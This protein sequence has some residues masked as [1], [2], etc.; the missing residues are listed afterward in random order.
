LPD[1]DLGHKDVLLA[2]IIAP[3]LRCCFPILQAVSPR[4]LVS[5]IRDA[6]AATSRVPDLF[7]AWT[8]PFASRVGR[9]FT[10]DRAY[11]QGLDQATLSDPRLRALFPELLAGRMGAAYVK[12]NGMWWKIGGGKVQGAAP[13]VGQEIA[14]YYYWMREATP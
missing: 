2:D 4:I 8:Q 12:Q 13:K 11:T 7:I 14:G 10:M 9:T 5:R 1:L 6:T 3:L